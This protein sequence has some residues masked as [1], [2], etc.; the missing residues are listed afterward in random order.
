M[1]LRAWL[2]FVLVSAA[3]LVL[4]C[5]PPGPEPQSGSE[6]HFLQSCDAPCEPGLTCVCGL[7]TALCD[8]GTGCST[9]SPASS[10]V[11]ATDR[12]AASSCEAAGGGFCDVA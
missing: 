7:C 5:T 8:S 11:S 3:T 9:V 12:A 4:S 6:S 10:C 1:S 2:L